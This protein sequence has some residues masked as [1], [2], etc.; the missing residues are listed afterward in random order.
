MRRWSVL[1]LKVL[2]CIF[3]LV[4]VLY[5]AAALYIHFK[6]PEILSKLTFELNQKINGQLTIEDVDPSFFVD[7]PNL[8][9][10]L[11]N[12]ELRD[13]LWSKHRHSPLKAREVFVSLNGLGFL[14]GLVSVS[15]IHL[16]DAEA[17]I[18]S[19][20]TGY[21]NASAFGSG[22]KKKGSGSKKDN[23]RLARLSAE[24]LSLVID[25]RH[26]NKLF[27]FLVKHYSGRTRYRSVYS[28][29]RLDAD[30]LVKDMAF[31]KAKGSFLKN[32]ELKGRF[33]MRYNR[34]DK[35]VSLKPA[36]VNI[37]G[38]DFLI[39]AFFQSN[40]KPTRFVINIESEKILWHKA[41]S[42]LAANISK[43]LNNYKL[44]KPVKL[45]AVLAGDFGPGSNPAIDVMCTVEK[46]VLHSPGGVATD[47]SFLG[48]FSNHVD[49]LKGNT[50]ENS[51]IRIL[52]FQGV[53][54]NIPLSM[55]SM[56]V[57]NLIH[58]VVTGDV[59]SEFALGKLAKSLGNAG[60]RFNG[61][62]AKVKLR[63]SAGIEGF[64]IVRPYIVGLIHIKNADIDY[65]PR[66][67]NFRSPEILLNFTK[68]DLLLNNIT[69]Q[70]GKSNISLRGK[71]SNFMSLY[72]KAPEKIV[73]DCE[74]YSKEIHPQ[75]FM[76]LLS[77]RKSSGSVKKQSA[78]VSQLN[79]ALEKS[80][81]NM[82][83]RLD[84]AVYKNF[85][86]TATN[87]NLT[88]SPEGLNVNSLSTRHA[89]GTLSASG[90]FRQSGAGSKFS[91][92]AHVGDVNVRTFFYA[93]NNFGLE[94]LTYRNL[95]GVL[96]VNADISGRLADGGALVPRS[97]DGLVTFDFNKGALLNFAPLK[98]V[99][100]IVFPFR[101]VSNI[102]F[103]RLKGKLDVNGEKI[104]INPMQINSSVLN[105]DIEGIYSLGKGTDINIDVPLRNPKKDVDIA[106]KKEKASR[107]MKG[108]VLHLE[109]IDGDDGKIKIQWNK[110]H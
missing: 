21:S 109:A 55:D 57:N 42:L 9:V 69:L 25:N 84:K 37:G 11:E 26:A 45:K 70:S 95:K 73:F 19:D 29:T 99:G 67:V 64:E 103:D 4:V 43:K 98:G 7:F 22:K 75:A 30:I 40:V 15:N 1:I 35:S 48:V 106:D 47:C 14:R 2:A 60:L 65:M 13:S 82:R 53:R 77:G 105:M 27:S 94:A 76:G 18:Y 110:D 80:T 33:D 66:S 54:E 12:V 16:K 62:M 36:K 61:G 58:P 74:V 104:R 31:N 91:L 41:S 92:K 85:V 52:K 102:T 6:K 50:D 24:N 68:K 46:N 88:F 8:S 10:K 39:S 28:D 51:R 5:T 78:M 89:G 96:S 93:F 71:V 63:F 34:E 56:I 17:Y 108:L 44:E 83:L 90:I 101:D 23:T 3:A 38:D 49:K 87:A 79:N 86:A 107:R 97:L 20:S 100:K 81:V 72:Y 59:K 32:K